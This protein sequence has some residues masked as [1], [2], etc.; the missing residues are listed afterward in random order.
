MTLQD[1]TDVLTR[2]EID[3][4]RESV[5]DPD[6][7]AA[8]E[9]LARQGPHPGR[10]IVRNPE[11][12]AWIVSHGPQPRSER[13]MA[14]DLSSEIDLAETVD[15]LHRE[16]RRFK[17]RETLRTFLHEVRGGSIRQTAGEIAA[18]AG[19][20]LD[21]ALRR[22][23]ELTDAQDVATEF[24]VFGMGKLG[25]RELNFSSDVDLVYMCSDRAMVDEAFRG[26]AVALARQLTDAIGGTTADGYAFRVDLRLRPDGS[27]GPLVQPI[28]ALVDYYLQYGR[29][30]E[31][32]A[33]VKARP[34]A[35][36]LQLGEDA[37]ERLEP[38][39]Y[40]RYLDFGAL[41][42]LRAMKEQIEANA[43]AV[44][45]QG[46][47]RANDETP[48]AEVQTS[49][50]GNRLKA[51]LRGTP[52]RRVRE[53]VV[54]AAPDE[55]VAGVLGW[56]VKIGEGGIR[57]IEFFIQALQLVHCGQ[58]PRLRVRR[59]LDALDVAMWAG[60]VSH[61][62]H[63]VLSDAY[64]FFRRLEHR[65]QMEEDRQ[66]HCVPQTWS[67]F[68]RL[69]SRL[70]ADRA[71]LV[72][73][74][75][76]HRRGVR[77]IFERLFRAEEEPSV[78]NATLPP[79]SSSEL[80][81]VSRASG[82]QLRGSG[83]FD[84]LTRLGFERPRQVAGQL[85]VLRDKPWGPLRDNA[86]G[87]DAE[88]GRRVLVE[89]SA[90]PDADLAFGHFS[91]FAQAVG[92]RPGY[93]A[94]LRD[95]P[96]ATRLLLQVF[97]SSSY[98]SAALIR[99]PN[100]FERLLSAG[101][102][103]IAKSIGVIGAELDER[104]SGVEDPEHRFGVIRRFHREEVLR[105]GLHE[106]GGAATIEQTTSQLSLLAE[107]VVG[108]VALEVYE[109]LRSR[110]RRPGSL[111]P[112]LAELPFTVVAMGKLGGRELGFGS[113]L[114]IVFVYEEERQYRLD[115]TFFARLAQRL[116]RTLSSASAEGKLY[117][118]DTRLR[119]SGSQ[120]ALVVSLDAF[121]DY[122]ASSASTWERQALLRA[123]TIL[124]PP[125]LRRAVMELR[126]ELAFERALGENAVA[127]IDEMRQKLQQAQWARGTRDVKFGPGGL[128]D[129]EFLTQS[130]QLR[131]PGE[132]GEG[133]RTALGKDVAP[134]VRS[135]ATLVAL[136]ALATAL[137]DETLERLAADYAFL[138]RVQARLRMAG[139]GS[140]NA[141]PE[142]ESALE[143][144]ARRMGHQG[145]AVAGFRAELEGVMRR[146]AEAFDRLVTADA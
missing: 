36:A 132:R 23:A 142:D 111:L 70:E 32:S 122:H 41:E 84:A 16:L 15:D 21:G 27:K 20:L 49:A 144:L 51:R 39:L 130:L 35:G 71:G 103:A 143:T 77:A 119:P 114:D 8:F 115:H 78:T 1:L 106:T 100:V 101:R 138:T 107:V 68:D 66:T 128:V 121:R 67:R 12:L 55:D 22:L 14:R 133:E 91:R 89:A 56:D 6:E 62:D 80:D 58:R 96:H 140:H 69:A 109:P 102:V 141:V 28:S 135:Q 110:K 120:G 79:T 104:L 26:R 93:W 134:G 33:W 124:G 47:S 25:G 52:R 48:S 123:R 127:E 105:I 29:T 131:H 3:S 136:R 10:L 24:C 34:V 13:E 38:F 86:W 60:L 108:R 74:I 40:R 139:D 92:D 46:T 11:W 125:R 116:V 9:A 94:M 88:L 112:E 126:E 129:I 113:D 83:V 59:T 18:L 72:E 44:A 81:L 145:D 85:E 75:T 31:R 98:L 82:D 37:L 118:V 65:I 146:A 53:P 45:V 95:S 17:Q 90:S 4:V 63:A 50:L 97:G 73:E 5:E 87:R 99:D 117:E 57:E 30:W 2:E 7:L 64:D 42:E 61:D 137:G 19:V 76:G 54:V 43:S